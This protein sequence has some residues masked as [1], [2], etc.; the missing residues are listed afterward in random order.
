MRVGRSTQDLLKQL[1]GEVMWAFVANSRMSFTE[2]GVAFNL[3][4]DLF[5]KFYSYCLQIKSRQGKPLPL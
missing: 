5:I 3:S 1:K 2:W 4:V